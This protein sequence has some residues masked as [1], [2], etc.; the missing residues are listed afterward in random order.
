MGCNNH[1]FYGVIMVCT[2]I[3]LPS[4]SWAGAWTMPVKSGQ[5]INTTL[6]DK[7]TRQ[8]NDEGELIEL[9]S[10]QKS[11]TSVYWEYGLLEKSTLVVQ[12]ALQDVTIAND[13]IVDTY[14]GTGESSI[15]IRYQLLNT[16]NWVVSSQASIVFGAGG[17]NISD[18]E[19]GFG[20]THAELRLL[21]G[22][23]FKINKKDAF[24][25]LQS[26]WRIRPKQ[27]PNDFRFDATFGVRPR[28]DILL[29]GQGFFV[30]T[31]G[32]KRLIRENRRLKLQA[33]IV[34]DR[35]K[36]TS[37]QIGAYQTVAGRNTVKEKA[38]FMGVWTR[39]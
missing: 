34:Y 12:A 27:N 4:I 8:Y 32:Y 26:A 30:K 16:D 18:A 24:V 5:L 23:G 17:E 22:R 13:G 37:Y 19:L 3:A 29:L 2:G 36:R 14:K 21:A 7:A 38:I 10:F 15:G 31:N 39:Y 35:S 6:F 33:S 20:N 1:W 25:D 9:D 28:S 11:E